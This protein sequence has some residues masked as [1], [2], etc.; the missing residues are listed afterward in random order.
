VDR[1]GRSTS[2]RSR[3]FSGPEEGVAFQESWYTLLKDGFGVF[4]ESI[5]GIQIYVDRKLPELER[6]LFQLGAIGLA[7]EVDKVRAEIAEE[8]VRIS[9]QNTLDEID[10]LEKKAADSFQ[11]LR[12]YETQ[13]T[14]MERVVEGWAV[15][16][17]KFGRNRDYDNQSVISY[18]YDRK[19]TLIPA[20][21][22]LDYFAAPLANQKGTYKREVALEHSGVRL[23]RIGEG[24]IDAL[25]KYVSWDDRGRVFAM[26]RQESN[27]AHAEH[28]NWIGLRFDYIVEVNLRE[29]LRE[30]ALRCPEYSIEAIR[31]R[32]DSLFPPLQLTMF[33]D[34]L[35]SEV[36]DPE[37]LKILSRR[38]SKSQPARDYNLNDDLLE[39]IDT[40][41]TSQQWAELCREARIRSE[42]ILR[43]REDFAT[44]C[45]RRANLAERDLSSRLDQ[46]RLRL[47][48]DYR[49]T[50]LGREALQNELQNERE[51][52]D[53]MVKGMLEPL[54]RLDSIGLIILS[55]NSL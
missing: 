43:R 33:L 30:F 8:K 35:M 9:E 22:F 29:T 3:V 51:L 10:A 5:A 4:S 23:Y 20:D 49:E 34:R 17:L 32:G 13:G 46:V 40:Y 1:I 38:Y 28:G 53:V 55:K 52:K 14:L 45:Q 7:E 12:E 19:Q 54:I 42:S 47:E 25:S 18:Q 44:E 26:W 39:V 50:S 2:V 16:A 11:E 31:R 15:E 27:S 37:L 6:I 48:R 21:L 36:V 24:F 41:F